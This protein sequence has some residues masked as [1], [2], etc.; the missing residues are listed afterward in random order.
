MTNKQVFK[1]IYNKLEIT[2][3]SICLE[4][5]NL[6]FSEYPVILKEEYYHLKDLLKKWKPTPYL[7]P[8][9]YKSKAFIKNNRYGFWW[10]NDKTG[11]RQRRKFLKT[12]IKLI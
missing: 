4:L 10:S 12:L 6:A 7:L 9:I 2:D 1:L 11:L 8:E 3:Q 5:Y